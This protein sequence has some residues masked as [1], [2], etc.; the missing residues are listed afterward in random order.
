[1]K[2]ESFG[3]EY[4]SNI[5]ITLLRMTIKILIFPNSNTNIQNTFIQETQSIEGEEGKRELEIQLLVQKFKSLN[6]KLKSPFYNKGLY[7][8]FLHSLFFLGGSQFPNL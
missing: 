2:G 7:M 3:K 6:I 1:M 4:K 8:K 5:K